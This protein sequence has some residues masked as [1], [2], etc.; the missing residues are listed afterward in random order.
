[1]VGVRQFDEQEVIGLPSQ[2]GGSTKQ[3]RRLPGSKSYGPRQP[4]R[5]AM[6]FSQRS[7]AG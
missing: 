3:C 2:A 7:I 4:G 5:E 6:R 1:M